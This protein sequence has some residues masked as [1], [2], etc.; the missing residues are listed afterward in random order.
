MY[1]YMKKKPDRNPWSEGNVFD[2]SLPIYITM[3]LFTSNKYILRLAAELI[4]NTFL[5]FIRYI[6]LHYSLP[7]L[8]LYNLVQIFPK[9][10]YSD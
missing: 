2:W 5:L 4:G 8:K 9:A 6:I 10:L 1:L 3:I 7:Y